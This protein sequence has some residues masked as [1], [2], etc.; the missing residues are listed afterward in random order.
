MQDPELTEAEV[1][2]VQDAVVMANLK[3]QAAERVA[4]RKARIAAGEEQEP[5]VVATDDPDFSVEEKRVPLNRAQ[6]RQ[7]VKLYAL[8]L[9]E[10]EKQTPV[11]NSTIIPRSQRRRR[12][13]QKGRLAHA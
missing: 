2:A 9:R 5:F 7:Q 6:R 10:T 1:K 4:A 11:R 13:G 3:A 8:L 12:A